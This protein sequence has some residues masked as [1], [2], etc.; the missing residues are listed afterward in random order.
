MRSNNHRTRPSPKFSSSPLDEM[1]S[2]GKDSRSRRDRSSSSEDSRSRKRRR[3]D[4]RDESRDRNKSKSSRG[5]DRESRNSKKDIKPR[6]DA[7]ERDRDRE[8]DR[9]RDRDKE[10][11]RKE[12]KKEF[13]NVND[14]RPSKKQERNDYRD[15]D[16]RDRDRKSND[17]SDNRDRDYPDEVRDSN[18]HTKEY[19][20]DDTERSSERKADNPNHKE[21]DSERSQG[22][23]LDEYIAVGLGSNTVGRSMEPSVTSASTLLQRLR[24]EWQSAKTQHE[25]YIT[26]APSLPWALET[27]PM[28]LISERLAGAELFSRIQALQWQKQ[29]LEQQNQQHEQERQEQAKNESKQEET[30]END[31]VVDAMPEEADVGVEEDSA[32]DI[33]V[34]NDED[35]DDLYGGLN[36][37]AI[38]VPV[39]TEDEDDLYGD[40]HAASTLDVTPRSRSNSTGSALALERADSTFTAS[41][42]IA[43]SESEANRARQSDVSDSA[44]HPLPRIDDDPLASTTH[45]YLLQVTQSTCIY[46]SIIHPFS[47]AATCAGLEYAAIGSA[48]SGGQGTERFILVPAGCGATQGT[49]FVDLAKRS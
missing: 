20:R 5:D 26:P 38:D 4:S 34:P 40:L 17:R 43:P 21:G 48:G 14:F 29:Q 32:M 37:S 8:R 2:R 33:A 23:H 15:R 16:R 18:K 31:I 10:K 24:S 35:E 9:G 22:S 11:D 19:D 12:V 30:V 44:W 39:S 27:L 36:A 45:R 28:A 47:F 13:A 41:P 42:A 6:E 7:Y 3:D 49:L 25:P 46:F 1:D